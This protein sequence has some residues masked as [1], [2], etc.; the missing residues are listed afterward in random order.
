[1][2]PRR[3]FPLFVAVP[4]LF[5]L[6]CRLYPSVARVAL[7][8]F[9]APVMARLHRLTAPIPFPV[10]EPLALVLAVLLTSSLSAALR[11]QHRP[12]FAVRLLLV[13]IT[14]L[15]MLWGPTLCLPEEPVPTPGGEQLAWLCGGLID[16]LNASPLAFPDPAEVLRRAPAVAGRPALCV[17]AVRWPEWMD[18]CRTWGMFIPLT[19]EALA[20]PLEPAPLLPFTAVHELMHLS[21][22]ADEG[23][24]NVAAWDRCMAA[25]GPFADSARLWALR[26]AMGQLHDSDRAAW[27]AAQNKMKA[28][29]LRTFLDCGAEAKSPTPRLLS[30]TCGDYAALTGYLAGHG[31]D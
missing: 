20:D 30:V 3:A 18:V 15:A 17:K 19:G 25:G 21:G 4:G 6:V 5:L 27:S 29:L 28:A 1:M 9:S 23:A 22:I 14:A 7:E 24:A 31:G 2:H 12:R 8:G 11:K 10:T 16:R 13:V 26:Y